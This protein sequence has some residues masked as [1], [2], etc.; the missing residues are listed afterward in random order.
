MYE[1]F[2]TN[3]FSNKSMELGFFKKIDVKKINKKMLKKNIKKLLE[4]FL[5]INL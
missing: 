3:K 2:R 5:Q 1:K 4:F